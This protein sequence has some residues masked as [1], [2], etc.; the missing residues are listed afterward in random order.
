MVE[1]RT[2]GRMLSE[3]WNR[4]PGTLIK[5]RGVQASGAFKGHLVTKRSKNL[6][7]KHCCT[8]RNKKRDLSYTGSRYGT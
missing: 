6:Q 8:G 3:V 5:K 4:K 2:H 1:R 7:S